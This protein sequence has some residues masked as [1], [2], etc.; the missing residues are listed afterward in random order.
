MIPLPKT[1]KKNGYNHE[2]IFR[3]NDYII[4]KL[5]S[6]ESGRF[7][8]YEAFKVR[9]NKSVEIL[10]SVIEEKETSPSNEEWGTYGYSVHTYQEALNKIECLKNRRR[11]RKPKNGRKETIQN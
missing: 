2:V 10:G 4:S 9:K 3:E 6:F 7:I 8:C 11:G 1:Y 5:T